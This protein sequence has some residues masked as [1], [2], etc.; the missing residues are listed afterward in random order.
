MPFP[1]EELSSQ[2]TEF[3]DWRATS[4]GN[5]NE[6]H[7]FQPLDK[8][9]TKTFC[10]IQ[11]GNLRFEHGGTLEHIYIKYDPM[12]PSAGRLHHI[13]FVLVNH[14]Q[15]AEASSTL[16]VD[17]ALATAK[18][19][20]KNAPCHSISISLCI[21]LLCISLVSDL[22]IYPSLKSKIHCFPQTLSRHG[23]K[24]PDQIFDQKS[25]VFGSQCF[26][27]MHSHAQLTAITW[28]HNTK[29]SP[30]P[31]THALLRKNRWAGSV[32]Y[33]YLFSVLLVV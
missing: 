28:H 30:I 22:I 15:P 27:G 23:L 32:L 31:S 18:L 5:L 1:N 7:L 33:Y 25:T 8:L 4:T 20:S 12:F 24:D 17:G 16:S 14:C 13:G 21:S 26:P 9:K 3:E 2:P 10:N 11:P 29:L 19:V 6:K